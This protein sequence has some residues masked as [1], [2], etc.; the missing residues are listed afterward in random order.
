MIVFVQWILH[1][2]R[3]EECVKILKKCKEAITSGEKKGKVIL[4]DTVAGDKERDNTFVETQM[5]F[6]MMLMAMVGGKERTEKEWAQL[7]NKAGFTDYKI[8]PILG[9][10]SLVEI[11][12]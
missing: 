7:F 2:W 3:D 1:V 11:Y 6:D 9:L 8:F 10:K 5:F 4:I 12:P